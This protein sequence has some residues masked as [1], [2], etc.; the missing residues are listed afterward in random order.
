LRLAQCSCTESVPPCNVLRSGL[1]HSS[2]N[3]PRGS[4][5]SASAAPESAGAT[6][7]ESTR[8]SPLVPWAGG[9]QRGSP[10]GFHP[11]RF[12][13]PG[14]IPHSGPLTLCQSGGTP[15]SQPRREHRLGRSPC[16]QGDFG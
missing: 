5:A 7:I 10:P 14:P 12:E 9:P 15:D 6:S 8:P 13:P 4:L 11:N 1:D 3:L 2:V 16:P